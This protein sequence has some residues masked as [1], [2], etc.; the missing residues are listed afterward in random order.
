[1]ASI[2]SSNI[3]LFFPHFHRRGEWTPLPIELRL[4][5]SSSV[6]F[7]LH[8]EL[9]FLVLT[10]VA[11]LLTQEDYLGRQPSSAGIARGDARRAEDARRGMA[12]LPGVTPR[13]PAAVARFSQ[14][15]CASRGTASRVSHSSG[16]TAIRTVAT[17]WPPARNPRLHSGVGARARRHGRGVQGPPLGPQAYRRHQDACCLPSI[18]SR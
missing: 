2:R 6:T 14:H 18:P 5:F 13:N 16:H 1:L 12:G 11:T 3:L 17:L 8:D 4:L 15:R 10:A 7:A 9:S